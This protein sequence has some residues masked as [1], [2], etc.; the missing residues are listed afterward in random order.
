M[1][2]KANKNTNN[3]N[4][5]NAAIFNVTP[6]SVNAICIGVWDIGK[7]KATF[8]GDE[9]I[10]QKLLIRFEVDEKITEGEYE[11]KNKC[12]SK[13]YNFTM[14]EKG[15]LRKDIS[16]WLKPFKDDNEAYDFDFD[17]LVGKPCLLSVVEKPSNGRVY[18]N[19]VSVNKLPKGMEAIEP[20]TIYKPEE[21]PEFIEK[22]R[23]KSIQ[24][25]EPEF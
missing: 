20:D 25:T 15:T 12:I 16:T 11:G 4:K 6:G 3:D 24:D 19:I 18:Q 1:S 10:K 9:T 13:W 8:S 14:H 2:L 22:I 17:T 21:T 5:G 23:A 7:W